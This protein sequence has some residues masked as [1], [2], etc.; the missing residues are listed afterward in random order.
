[1]LAE[2]GSTMMRLLWTAF[3]IARKYGILAGWR[4][5]CCGWYWGRKIQ[6]QRHEVVQMECGLME[7][8]D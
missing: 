2:E 7:F 5:A 3:R 6:R 4:A 8:E 1:M